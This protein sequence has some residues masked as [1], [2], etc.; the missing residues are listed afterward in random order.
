MKPLM[1]GRAKVALR[2]LATC[3]LVFVVM[4][5]TGVCSLMGLQGRPEGLAAVIH[6]I[7]VPVFL[8]LIFPL[9]CLSPQKLDAVGYA[10][11]PLTA[12]LWAMLIWI[13]VW[14]ARYV[15]QKFRR[16]AF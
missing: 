5:V 11:I 10:V 12:V 8:C 15:Y 16:S 1:T 6:S 3:T 14:L 2:F 4:F 13:V 7:S 9:Q